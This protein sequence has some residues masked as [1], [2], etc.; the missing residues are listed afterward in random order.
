[1]KKVYV[2]TAGLVVALMISGC[3]GSSS[4]NAFQGTWSGPFQVFSS[5]GNSVESSGFMIM[6]V[7][8]FGGAQ[9]E[10]QRTDSNQQTQFFNGGYIDDAEFFRY[11]WRWND[12]NDR[13]TKGTVEINGNFL[14]P[15]AQNRRLETRVAG[16]ATGGMEFTLTRQ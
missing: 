1:M 12:T 3:G 11:V 14:Q 6:T 10:M 15:A 8:S 7:D 16:G 2:A 13:E 4:K 9:V 5:S